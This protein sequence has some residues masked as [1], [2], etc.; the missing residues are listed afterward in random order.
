MKNWFCR[1]F[2]H[3]AVPCG[4]STGDPNGISVQGFLLCCMRCGTALNMWPVNVQPDTNM[5]PTVSGDEDDV[6]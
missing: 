5:A 3:K 2:G 4:W 1:L 6:V